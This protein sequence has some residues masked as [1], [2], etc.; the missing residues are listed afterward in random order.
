MRKYIISTL[1][2]LDWHIEEDEFHE[3]TPLNR[4]R[5]T[6]VIATKDPSASRRVVL[7][8]H[9]D[10]KYFANYPDNQVCCRLT[11]VAFFHPI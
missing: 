8:A 1:K 4:T 5:F 9:H 6:N 10:S 2:A 3:D 11:S 7:S